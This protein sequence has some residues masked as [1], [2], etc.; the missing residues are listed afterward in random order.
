MSRSSGRSSIGR[1]GIVPLSVYELLCGKTTAI[2]L[3]GLLA[4]HANSDDICWPHQEK[5]AELLGVSV[6]TIRRELKTIEAAGLLTIA[7]HLGETGRMI[8]NEYTVILPARSRMDARSETGQQ[9]APMRADEGAADR[10]SM[11]GDGARPRASRGRDRLTKNKTKEQTPSPNGDT[12]ELEGMPTRPKSKRD[13]D[14]LVAEAHALT[15]RVFANRK[16]RPMPSFLNV[17]AL[18]ESALRADYP[19]TEIERFM[20]RPDTVFTK[21]GFETAVARSQGTTIDPAVDAVRRLRRMEGR[22]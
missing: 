19:A 9:R 18:A 13:S 10:A 22:A 11:R 14:P 12:G 6:G 20:M 8:G 15:E 4:V 2:A 3:Y 16:P 5:L 17:R 1:Y 7:P 21:A